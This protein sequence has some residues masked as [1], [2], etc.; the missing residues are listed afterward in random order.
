MARVGACDNF[1]EAFASV[2]ECERLRGG[3]GQACMP[4]SAKLGRQGG[5]W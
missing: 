3:C 4:P 2:G 5:W 1:V